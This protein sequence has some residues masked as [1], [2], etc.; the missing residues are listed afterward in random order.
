MSNSLQGKGGKEKSDKRGPQRK[1]ELK[2]G[3]G[4]KPAVT[5]ESNMESNTEKSSK[6]KGVASAT[7]SQRESQAS[8]QFQ[9]EERSYY[10][11]NGIQKQQS[12]E[13]WHSDVQRII[14]SDALNTPNDIVIYHVK[15]LASSHLQ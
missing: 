4:N 7:A 2:A 6:S 3:S 9:L 8:S 11:C 12:Y 14:E 13:G 10:L 15:R 1:Q 5:T